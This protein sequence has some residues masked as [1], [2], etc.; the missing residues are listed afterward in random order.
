MIEAPPVSAGA[1]NA[2]MM[3]DGLARGGP[4]EARKR[5]DDFW[6]ASSIDGNLPALQRSV[7]D[8]LFSFMPY[9]GSPAQAWRACRTITCMPM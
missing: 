9:E 8:R 5:L 1:M 6:R 7:M 2:V 3:T 4:E